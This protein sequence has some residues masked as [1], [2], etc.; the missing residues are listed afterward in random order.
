MKQK[1]REGSAPCPLKNL[2]SCLVKRRAVRVQPIGDA[3]FD[4]GR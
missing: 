2:G 3:H 4:L 1:E